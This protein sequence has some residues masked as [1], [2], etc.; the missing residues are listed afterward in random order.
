[1]M[2]PTKHSVIGFGLGVVLLGAVTGCVGYVD[3]PRHGRVYA[4]SVHDGYVYY[5]GYQVYY[6][7]S[8]HHYIY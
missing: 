6:S 7:T 8:R 2:T 1:M 3:G 5:P 4:P